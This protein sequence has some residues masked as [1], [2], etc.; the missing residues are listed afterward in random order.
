MNPLPHLV[1]VV[2]VSL[3]AIA[4]AN[5]DKTDASLERGRLWDYAEHRRKVDGHDDFLP[6]EKTAIAAAGSRI[7]AAH[8]RGLAA[9]IALHR[10]VTAATGADRGD[11]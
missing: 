7:I 9:R 3:Q 1:A 11:G 10:T 2:A 5:T 4:Q 8:D 6:S